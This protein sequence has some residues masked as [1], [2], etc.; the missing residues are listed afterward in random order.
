MRKILLSA[1]A[2]LA[3]GAGTAVAETTGSVGVATT[4]N[5]YEN[6]YD[7]DTWEFNGSIFH[8]V[9]GPWAVQGELGLEEAD[10]GSGN[11]DD[12]HHYAVH[13][14]YAQDAYT[15]GV[16]GGQ[17]EIFDDLDIDFFG[18]EGAYRFANVTVSGSLI[19]GEAYDAVD[20][21][22]Y[23]VGGRYF[24]GDNIA[25][26]AN[27][28][29]TDY[30]NTDW[31][32]WDV[33]GDY[34][35]GSLPITLSATYLSQEGDFIDVDTWQFGARWS[36]GTANLREDDRNAPIANADSYVAD[37]RRWD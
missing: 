3:V 6:G 35:F 10:Y 1:A 36:F 14:L 28:A 24:F 11:D 32:T 30:S 9:A 31:D 15:L 29:R 27:Y 21:D 26:G 20:Y 13:G 7:Y 37:L 33:G 16:F 25:V 19:D 18:A 2:M 22:R 4:N 17:A 8:R 5:E 12:G 23:R 34:R